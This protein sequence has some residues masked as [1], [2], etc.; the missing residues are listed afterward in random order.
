M[1]KVLDKGYIRLVDSM[2]SDLSVVT[3]QEFLMTD[4]QMN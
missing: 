4:N 3:V 1:I 2:G